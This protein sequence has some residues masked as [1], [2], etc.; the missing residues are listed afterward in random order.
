ML[1]G[2]IQIHNLNSSGKVL[3]GQ[4]P[5]P[6]GPVS[7]DY[8]EGGPFPT[9]APSFRIDTEAEFF[10]RL[11]GADVGGG[12]RVADGPALRIQGG[13]GEHAAELAL[14]GAGAL[15]FDPGRPPL[16]FGGR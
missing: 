12:L 8:L 4:I 9:S 1:P 2:V 11:D 3:V 7:Q 16:R 15:S 13:L 6:D 14:A 5:N 10:G